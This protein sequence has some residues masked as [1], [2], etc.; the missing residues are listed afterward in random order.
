MLTQRIVK[1][2]CYTALL[3]AL[4]L[5]GGC[6]RAERAPQSRVEVLSFDGVRGMSNSQMTLLVTIRNNSG[7]KLC[8]ERGK[9]HIATSATKI[10][11]ASLIEPIVV[12]RR[13]TTPVEVQLQL[14]LDNPIY[15]A[16]LL[17]AVRRGS[18][19]NVK[20]SLDAT[21]RTGALRHNIVRNEMKVDELLKLL[22]INK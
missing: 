14:Q 15:A 5:A 17:S 13:T 8:V 20:L 19:P 1:F 10:A 21:I 6:R 7:S 16:M 4:L 12:P 22:N 3:T 9:L 11:S 2:I 18:K